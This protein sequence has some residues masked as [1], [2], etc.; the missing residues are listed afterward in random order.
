[1]AN[2][3]AFAASD[4]A[5]FLTGTLIFADGGTTI[6]KAARETWQLCERAAKADAR[7]QALR[8]TA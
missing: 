8:T 3:F 7:P 5:S 4:E 2:A 1:M 6:A